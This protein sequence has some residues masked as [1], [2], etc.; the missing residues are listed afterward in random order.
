MGNNHLTHYVLLSLGE[1]SNLIELL[2]MAAY[3]VRAPDGV[4]VWF[5]S[6]AVH[7]WGRTPVLGD[8]EERFCGAHKLFHADGSFMAHCETPVALAMTTGASTHEEEVIIE[9]PDRSR[10][11][12][13]VHIDPIRDCAGKVTGVVN[14]FHDITDQ[15]AKESALRLKLTQHTDSLRS[16]SSQLMRLQDDERRHISRELHDSV[17][18]HLSLAQMSLNSLAIRVP[19]GDNVLQRLCGEASR[20]LAD[21]V[22]ELRTISYL[23]HPPLLDEMGFAAAVRWYGDGLSKRSGIALEVRLPGD[24][25]RLTREK[26]MALFRVVQE[27]LSNVHRHSGARKATIS[28]AL[29]GEIVE[30]EIADHGRGIPGATLA[31]LA[32]G[33]SAHGVGIR[34]MRER[35]REFQ[36]S[37]EVLSNGDGT[38]LLA[39]LPVADSKPAM[40]SS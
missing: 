10:V 12:V 15:K 19:P 34:G 11:T 24:M 40:A 35:L 31:S 8:T 21:A 26:E 1:Q 37:L 32:D 20:S 18:Q 6:H 14:F 5:N 36:G 4:I 33:K 17:G 29:K 7:L 28:V 22:S 13:S 38:R 39:S 9:R 27:G 3:I 23:L 16:L 30:L 2:P 25:P